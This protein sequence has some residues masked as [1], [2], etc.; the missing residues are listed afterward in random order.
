MILSEELQK[1]IYDQVVLDITAA[2]LP[3][4]LEG[5]IVQD[6]FEPLCRIDWRV[7]GYENNDIGAGKLPEIIFS[8]DPSD[9]Y[10]AKIGAKITFG[11]KITL[12]TWGDPASKDRYVTVRGN[13]KFGRDYHAASNPHAAATFTITPDTPRDA[14]WGLKAALGKPV[15]MGAMFRALD[16]S[17]CTRPRPYSADDF[18]KVNPAELNGLK[19]AGA[20]DTPERRYYDAMPAN[21]LVISFGFNSK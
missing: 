6:I 9:L 17:M 20:K 18:I 7:Y 21:T 15:T 16:A 4:S 10:Q 5:L 1:K 3:I 19:I 2:E 8:L 13:N 12:L 14:M 11:A